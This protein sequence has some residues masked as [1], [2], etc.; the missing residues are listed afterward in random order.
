MLLLG[1]AVAASTEDGEGRGDGGRI[2]GSGGLGEIDGGR[3]CSSNRAAAAATQRWA[4]AGGHRR[5]EA[6]A[7][8]HALQPKPKDR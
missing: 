8:L 1:C 5:A 6:E 4:F 3:R 7:A 2:D